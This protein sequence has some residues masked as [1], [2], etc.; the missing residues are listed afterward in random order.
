MRVQARHPAAQQHRRDGHAAA[1][2]RRAAPGSNQAYGVDGT[3]AF[4]DNLTFDTYWA[5]TRVRGRRPATTRATA[6]SWTTAATATACSSSACRSATT[7]TPRSASC[8]ATTCARTTRSCASA[9]ARRRI[10]SVR[11]FSS[12]GPVHLHREQRRAA[13][14]ADRGRRVRR[15]VPEQ[16]PLQRRRQRRLRVPAAA[17]RHRAGASRAGGRLRVHDRPDRLQ[18]G[19]AARSRATCSSSTGLLQRRPDGRYLQPGAS[20]VIAAA[21]GR[22][23]RLGQL[24][25]P[26]D[27][28]FTT[29]LVGSRVT[30]TM[31][32]LM[33][34]SALVQYNSS[35][36]TGEHQRPPALGVPPG[37]RAVRRLQRGAR[38]RSGGRT[39]GPAEP[40]VHREGEPV[41]PLLIGGRDTCRRRQALPRGRGAARPGAFG[42]NRDSNSARCACRRGSSGLTAS[43]RSERAVHCAQASVVRP[44]VISASPYE[45][46]DTA[47]SRSHRGC[48]FAVPASG[49]VPGA[50]GSD[51]GPSVN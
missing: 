39:A 17:V 21:L 42:S 27:G 12:I 5:K 37:Q 38:Q 3:F 10:K 45:K 35:T 46:W 31:T 1:R 47:T 16:R 14:D 9:R 25:R 18:L 28:S 48:A 32:P 22:A 2:R 33:F 30:Y 23:E 4:F 15:R 29:T 19:P 26:A 7:S 11:K 8:A 34:V 6:R 50:R 43:C 49:A 41:L 51:G 40:R 24:G 44:A 13:R 36:H 20:N